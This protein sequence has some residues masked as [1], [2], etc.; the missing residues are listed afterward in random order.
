MN[1]WHNFEDP[2]KKRKNNNQTH[3]GRPPGVAEDGGAPK[4][5]NHGNEIAYLYWSKL[6]KVDENDKNA[7]DNIFQRIIDTIVIIFVGCN[8]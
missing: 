3:R 2:S 8:I 4:V 7:Y 6:L 5:H 1:Y